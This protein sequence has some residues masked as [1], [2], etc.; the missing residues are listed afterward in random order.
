MVNRKYYSGQLTN[1]PIK[2]LT[3]FNYLMMPEI[4]KKGEKLD[5]ICRILMIL[6]IY[7]ILAAYISYF[8]AK[9]QLVSPL[10]PRRT[11]NQ[12]LYDSNDILMRAGIVSGILFL[13]GLWLYTFNKK[14]FAI[15]LFIAVPVCFQVLISF[16]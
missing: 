3:Q 4:S 5:W 10:I 16:S 11:I 15:I 6:D 2:G 14:I 13:A 8:Q 12:I 9:W 1:L 7:V